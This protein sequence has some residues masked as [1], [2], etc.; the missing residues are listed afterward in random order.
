MEDINDL[1]R[2]LFSYT[3]QTVE[4]FQDNIKK[5]FV[6][7]YNPERFYDRYFKIYKELMR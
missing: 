3:E 7:D 6:E 5:R 1:R 4:A 2:A